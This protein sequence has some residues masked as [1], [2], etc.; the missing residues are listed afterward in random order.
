MHRPKMTTEDRAKLRNIPETLQAIADE[1]T[2]VEKTT[3]ESGLK[4]AG[5]SAPMALVFLGS[6]GRQLAGE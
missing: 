6:P 3:N 2:Q 1:L 4:Q 5:L